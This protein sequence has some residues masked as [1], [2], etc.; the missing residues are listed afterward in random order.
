MAN[1]EIPENPVYD[2]NIRKL[3]NTDPAD[4]DGIFN[5][6]FQKLVGN[7]H[8]VKQGSAALDPVTGLIPVEEMPIEGLNEGLAFVPLAQDGAG[9]RAIAL[10]KGGAKA[11]GAGSTGM[12]KISFP[13]PTG[14]GNLRLN[15]KSLRADPYEL[16]LTAYWSAGAFSYPCAVLTAKK[17]EITAARL[18]MDGARPCAL[19]GGPSSVWDWTGLIASMAMSSPSAIQPDG[20]EISLAASDAGVTGIVEAPVSWVAMDSGEWH[21]MVLQNGFQ[22]ANALGAEYRKSGN[23]VYLR[24]T[25]NNSSGT[26]LL[27]TIITILPAGYKPAKSV[28]VLTPLSGTGGGGYCRLQIDSYG[29]VSVDY[30]NNQASLNENFNLNCSFIAS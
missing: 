22:A 25:V 16:D 19:L 30:T 5:P 24:G 14:A 7:I 18:G 4:A 8:A 27:S 21:A 11:F 26:S 15:I 23:I 20:W 17:K 28:Y 29:A 6:L 10:P 9:A 12:I 1:Y 2:E 3:E 13:P